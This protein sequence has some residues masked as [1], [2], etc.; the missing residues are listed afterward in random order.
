MAYNKIAVSF[1][2]LHRSNSTKKLL[3]SRSNRILVSKTMEG[4]ALK[5]QMGQQ[6]IQMSHQN[7]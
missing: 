7:R 1:F 3:R 4:S 2:L 6:K 5:V